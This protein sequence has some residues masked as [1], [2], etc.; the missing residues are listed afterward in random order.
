MSFV[1]VS[2]SREDGA[3]V[4]RLAKRL[5]RLGIPV[6]FDRHMGAAD[7]FPE[8]TQQRLDAAAAV[9]V[10][11]SPNAAGSRWVQRE[12]YYATAIGKRIFPFELVE[13]PPHLML[14]DIQR[15]DVTHGHLPDKGTLAEL[16]KLVDAAD[17]DDEKSDEHLRRASARRAKRGRRIVAFGVVAAL[18]V[19]AAVGWLLSPFGPATGAGKSLPTFMAPLLAPREASSLPAHP[20]ELPIVAEYAGEGPSLFAASTLPDAVG[21]ATVGDHGDVLVTHSAADE[22]HLL[23]WRKTGAATWRRGDAIGSF[24]SRVVWARLAS[25]GVLVDGPTMSLWTIDQSAHARKLTAIPTSQAGAVAL[26]PD[27]QQLAVAING[28]VQLW[29]VSTP[30]T[31]RRAGGFTLNGSLSIR[32]LSYDYTGNKLIVAAFGRI[33]SIWRVRNGPTNEL[34]TLRTS[35]PSNGW[36]SVL[37][38]ALSPDG[39][40]LAT[41]EDDGAVWLWTTMNLA[42]VVHIATLPAKQ[43]NDWAMSISFSANG[44]FVILSRYGGSISTWS[45]R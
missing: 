21:P 17:D 25:V 42:N 27:G 22:D 37:Y 1:F 24:G 15:V 31:P 14:A 3:Y 20:M 4:K 11:V 28:E 9:V 30:A 18:V 13:S 41:A 36:S 26:S 34:V 12:L 33:V 23:I 35:P 16:R 2:Y 8:T 43:K 7:V 45:L 32:S 40:L 39:N 19:L 29:D 10:I 5:P 44:H 38:A 6:W